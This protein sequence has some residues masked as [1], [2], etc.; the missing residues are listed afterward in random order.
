MPA[1]SDSGAAL[2]QP[3]SIGSATVVSTTVAVS[4]ADNFMARASGR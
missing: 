3:E 2:V 1:E 4:K